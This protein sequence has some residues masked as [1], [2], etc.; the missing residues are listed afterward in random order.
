MITHFEAEILF[1]HH[2]C[3]LLRW[4][5][6]TF[7]YSYG[8]CYATTARHSPS[9]LLGRASLQWRLLGQFLSFLRKGRIS[10]WHCFIKSHAGP[11][12]KSHWR[13]H[14]RCFRVYRRHRKSSGAEKGAG[15]S[16]KHSPLLQRER[17]YLGGVGNASESDCPKNC[18]GVSQSKSDDMKTS[19]EGQR[20][21]KLEPG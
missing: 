16:E 7:F 17:T 1:T 13:P 6:P 3:H 12:T 2:C 15:S 5:Q 8:L 11:V 4:E 10:A 18:A 19:L 9:R 14:N 21:R 20:S